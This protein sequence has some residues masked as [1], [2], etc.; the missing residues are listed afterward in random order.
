MNLKTFLKGIADAIRTAKGT[1]SEIAAKDFAAKIKT[2]NDTSN[3]TAVSANVLSGKTAYSKGIKITGSMF[4]RGAINKQLS[5]SELSYTIPEGYHNGTGKVNV[6]SETKNCTPTKNKQT[7]SPST[8]YLLS[9]VTV[10]AI[11]N[12]Y[13]DTTDATATAADIALNKTAYVNGAKLTGTK[14]D[15]TYVQGTCQLSSGSYLRNCTF[16]ANNLQLVNYAFIYGTGNNNG[17]PV[18]I[19]S[20]YTGRNTSEISITS[21]NYIRFSTNVATTSSTTLTVIAIGTAR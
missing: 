5:S 1:T 21:N 13:I 14:R 18:P 7:V 4:D 16:S 15:M 6:K 8:G 19:A 17:T 2:L 11:P 10:E 20:A 12:K 9:S 3:T